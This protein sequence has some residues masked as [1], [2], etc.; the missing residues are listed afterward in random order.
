MVRRTCS[1]AEALH[2]FDQERNQGT[3][4]L[5][6]GLGLLIQIGLIGRSAA[7]GYH[8]EA[9][10]HTLCSLDVDL[11]REV[12]AGV[13]FV[14][15]IQR[16]VLAVTQVLLRVGLEY[17]FGDSFLIFEA[18]PDLLSLFAVNDGSTRILAQWQFALGCNFGITQEG[19]CNIL[20]VG[21]GFGVAQNL[22]HLFVVAATQ[23][24]AYIAEGSI[25][26]AGKCFG[27][28]LQDRLTLEL[29]NAHTLLGQEVVFGLV[30]A[31]LEHRGILEFY[32]CH[33]WYF[34]KVVCVCLFRAGCCPIL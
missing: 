3:R 14:V 8:Q 1:S 30:F 13:L 28:N 17:T 11:G 4:V 31:Q 21:A 16:S 32:I 6:A 2:R 24:E 33:S 27:S 18:G 20:V 5:D 29:A 15:H 10:F 7:L 22:C 12:A 9:V 23:Q 19:Q 26:H 34:F 25:G